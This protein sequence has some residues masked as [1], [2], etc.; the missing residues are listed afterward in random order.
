M[1]PLFT[2]DFPELLV[3]FAIISAIAAPFLIGYVAL[4]VAR[5]VWRIAVALESERASQ[6]AA[7][8]VAQYASAPP[9]DRRPGRISNSAFGR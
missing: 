8:S 4:S 3:F 7:K 6:T 9:A 2:H 1:Q 5:S